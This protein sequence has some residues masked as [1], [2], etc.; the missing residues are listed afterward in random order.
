MDVD[1]TGHLW[2]PRRDTEEVLKLTPDMTIAARY[3]I[4]GIQSAFCDKSGA[5]WVV[6]RDGAFKL[7]PTGQPGQGYALPETF[8]RPIKGYDG[9]VLFWSGYSLYPVIR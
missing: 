6:D 9:S 1:A 5:P 3:P 2:L 8:Q 4:A 7:T